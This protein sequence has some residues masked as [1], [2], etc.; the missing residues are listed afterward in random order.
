VAESNGPALLQLTDFD[1]C[2]T[3]PKLIEVWK[4]TQDT[5]PTGATVIAFTTVTVSINLLKLFIDQVSG[6][7]I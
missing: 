6:L 7:I 5:G 2:P 4:R 1:G 3:K